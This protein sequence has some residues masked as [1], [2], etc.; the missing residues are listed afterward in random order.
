MS[1]DPTTPR[2]MEAKFSFGADD[3]ATLVGLQALGGLPLA[4]H[5]TAVQIDVYCDTAERALEVVGST[6]RVRRIGEQWRMTFKGRSERQYIGDTIV[7]TRVE[8]EVVIP[9]DVAAAVIA[10]PQV[11]LAE[12]PSPLARAREAVG[13]DP[14]VMI[15]RIENR[16]TTLTF[17]DADADDGVAVEVMIDRCTGMRGSD[18]REVQFNELEAELQNGTIETL[19]S[20]I[21][22]LRIQVPSVLP[23]GFSKL[24]RVMNDPVAPEA[25]D[26]TEPVEQLHTQETQDTQDTQD[27]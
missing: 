14:L 15:A 4:A 9:A 24:G 10:D 17:R 21:D 26:L 11:V 6:F 5:T 16:R 7:K 22:D 8:D 20:V 23:S 25:S 19:T 27:T 12:V 13:A 3:E 1:A 18:G 2:E